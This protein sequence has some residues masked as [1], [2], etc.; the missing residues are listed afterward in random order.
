LKSALKYGP[1]ISEKDLEGQAFKL[2]RKDGGWA[3]NSK[4]LEFSLKIR[5]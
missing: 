2:V 1:E 3:L 4:E 5:K